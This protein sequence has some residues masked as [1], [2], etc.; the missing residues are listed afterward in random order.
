MFATRI[1]FITLCFSFYTGSHGMFTPLEIDNHPCQPEN[2][3]VSNQFSNPYLKT[4]QRVL[5]TIVTVHT[6]LDPILE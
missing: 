3:K 5:H 1:I 6:V 4:Q 2:L